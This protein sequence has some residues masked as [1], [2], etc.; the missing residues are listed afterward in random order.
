[1][2]HPNQT[3]PYDVAVGPVAADGPLYSIL[4]VGDRYYGQAHSK[5]ND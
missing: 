5:T 3:Y 1:M 2:L 4:E